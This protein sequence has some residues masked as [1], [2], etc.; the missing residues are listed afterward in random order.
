MDYTNHVIIVLMVVIIA[1][2]I[3]DISLNTKRVVRK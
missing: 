2:M 3:R 1:L